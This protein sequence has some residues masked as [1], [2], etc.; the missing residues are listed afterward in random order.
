MESKVDISNQIPKSEPPLNRENGNYKQQNQS[1]RRE[2]KE[3]PRM[4]TRT[5]K[6]SPKPDEIGRA[7]NSNAQGIT[8]T[9]G[10]R[11]GGR[12]TVTR[13]Q[14]P[15]TQKENEFIMSQNYTNKNIG[16][17]IQE[18][19]NEMSNISLQ[20]GGYG[21]GR[22]GKFSGPR[23][24]SVPPRLQAEQRGSKRY[25]SLRQRSLP[26]TA[27]QQ[28]FNQHQVIHYSQGNVTF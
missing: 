2:Y 26:E 9:R 11:G 14:K 4:I 7:I 8:R 10:F 16:Q 25:S 20:D 15:L 3:Q 27:A 22:G 21:S 12:G 1:P 13:N 28:S 19:E 17:Q 23:Q 6:A 5:I 18:V 24:V